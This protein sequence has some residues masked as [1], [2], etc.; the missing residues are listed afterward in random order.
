MLLDV[1]STVQW[2]EATENTEHEFF[3]SGDF[4]SPA[5][6]HV[7]TNSYK[8]AMEK[9]LGKEYTVVE[10]TRTFEIYTWNQCY[11]AASLRRLFEESGFQITEFLSDVAGTP[12]RDDSRWIAVIADPAP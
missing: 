1:A 12:S 3:A 4:W 6:H 7:L 8:Y 9:L 11:D 2:Q 5:P 10:E